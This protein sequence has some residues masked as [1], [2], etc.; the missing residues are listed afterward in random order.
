MEDQKTFLHYRDYLW[1]TRTS[2]VE[3]THSYSNTLAFIVED[4]F[5]SVLATHQPVFGVYVVCQHHSVAEASLYQC[6]DLLHP[7]SIT[8]YVHLLAKLVRVGVDTYIVQ[9]RH[10]E[11]KT[12]ILDTDYTS[13]WPRSQAFRGRGERPGDYC[14]RMRERYRLFSV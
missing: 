12:G 11:E 9:T 10:K 6:L 4:E 8:R 2:T 1:L 7:L 14:V 13:I 5:N 3:H